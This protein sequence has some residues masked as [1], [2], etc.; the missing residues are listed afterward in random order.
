[1]VTILAARADGEKPPRRGHAH[2]GR[3]ARRPDPFTAFCD[4][5]HERFG[6]GQRTMT[7][8]ERA[9]TA[10]RNRYPSNSV[11]WARRER[12]DTHRTLLVM[13]LSDRELW[14]RA[15]AGSAAAFGVLFE[16]HG[17]AVYNYCF[18]RRGAWAEAEDLASATFLEAWR[19]RGE[20]RLTGDSVRPWLL[21][22]ATN[23]LRNDIRSRYRREAALRKLDATGDRPSDGLADDVAERL[24][25]QRRM[26]D[27]LARLRQLPLEQ[28]EVVALVLWSELSY[29][30]A[31]VALNVPVGTVKSRLS[32]ARRG[33]VEPDS[34]SGHFMTEGNALARAST[35]KPR[36]V[37]G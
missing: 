25:D 6:V 33:L 34:P 2:V 30:E 1:V 31:A 28:Q 8:A 16:R 32:R 23:L 35:T 36:E 29:E 15:A 22:I 4:V 5:T 18:R 24:D 11:S 20:V 10:L 9:R 12:N 21:G 17:S 19:R 7:T 3:I 14:D 26:S 13:E 27:I 37:E